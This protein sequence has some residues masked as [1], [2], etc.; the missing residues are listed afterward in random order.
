[1]LAIGGYGLWIFARAA[2]RALSGTR[3]ASV[4]LPYLSPERRHALDRTPEERLLA[5]LDEERSAGY[6]V[7]RYDGQSAELRRPE[8]WPSRGPLAD[9]MAALWR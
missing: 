3:R 1:M 2:L 7:T 8:W 6:V 5:F 9:F 4:A